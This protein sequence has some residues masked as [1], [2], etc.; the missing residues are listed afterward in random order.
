MCVSHSRLPFCI[1]QK[2]TRNT[3]HPI[4]IMVLNFD[5]IEFP[6]TLKN[7]G[8]FEYLN[9]VLINIYVINI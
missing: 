3:N 4:H 6:M 5:N 9:N 2:E 8:K 1:L 7:I